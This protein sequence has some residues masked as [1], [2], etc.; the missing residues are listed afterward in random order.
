MLRL[1]NVFL[2]LLVVV[3]A[4]NSTTLADDKS[5]SSSIVVLIMDPLSKALACDCVQGYAQRDY[6]QLGKYLQK[7]LKQP[8]KVVFGESINKA[9]KGDLN[10]QVDLI[11]GKD[12]V[13]RFDLKKSK[14]QADLLLQLT[15]KQGKTTQ[16]GLFVVPQ[17][18]PALSV[19]DLVNYRIFFGPAD[20]A[21][22]HQAP[23]KLL[24]DLG[25]AMP[26]NTETCPS[27]SDG[28]SKILEFGADVRAAAVIS[29]YAQPLLEGCG[30]IQKGDLRVIGESAPVPFISAFINRTV[31]K[32]RR[33]QIKLALL[34]VAK[35]SQ[36]K[37]ALETK[38]GFVKPK[39]A[40]TKPT[41]ASKNSS[42]KSAKPTAKKK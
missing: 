15:D 27:C 5:D 37:K 14:R 6:E 11:I 36:L 18:D 3:G 19:V 4:R 22:K 25:V 24:T 12:S 31:S 35:D 42:I 30:T 16:T 2:I 32:S 23:M 7:R 20:S 21:E 1:L 33:K 41:A 17:A 40:K 8:V 29:S 39:A 10:A 13:V 28:A 34:D 26:K 38:N 9:F